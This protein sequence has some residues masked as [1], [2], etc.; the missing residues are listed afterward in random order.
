MGLS[1]HHSSASTSS[2]SSRKP[3]NFS[4]SVGTG[5]RSG[6]TVERAKTSMSFHPPTQSTNPRQRANTARARPQTAMSSHHTEEDPTTG[7]QNCTMPPISQSQSQSVSSLYNRRV[8][9]AAS[10]QQMGSQATTSKRDVSIN[11]MMG[12]L[13][14]K[15]NLKDNR[16]YDRF[17]DRSQAISA[18]ENRPPAPAPISLRPSSDQLDRV[19]LRRS[20]R[21]PFSAYPSH[22]EDPTASSLA[23]PETPHSTQQVQQVLE[24]FEITLLASTRKYTGSP[25]KSPSKGLPFLTKDSNTRT[26][27]A[28]D[29]DERLVEVEAQFKAMKEV[30]NVSLSDKKAM[31]EVIEMAKTRGNRSP[32]RFVRFCG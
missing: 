32:R 11:T 8:R 6:A 20:R 25:S 2:I 26:F 1:R 7:K 5:V 30:M 16:A 19:V 23:A 17:S 13:S 31:E 4:Q 3:G 22:P 28:W 14:L 18:K 21:E 24:D 27:I 10:V 9:K 29:M 15:D 12:N